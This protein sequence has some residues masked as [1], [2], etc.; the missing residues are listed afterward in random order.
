MAAGIKFTSSHFRLLCVGLG[1]VLL[2]AVG[3]IWNMERYVI[4][5]LGM[6]PT[7]VTGDVV[8]IDRSAYAQNTPQRGDIVFLE[9]PDE[10][11]M[12]KRIIGLPGETVEVRDSQVFVDGVLLEESYIDNPPPY[13]G[14]W[15]C[16]ADEYFVLGDN[17]ANSRDSHVFGPIPLEQISGRVLGY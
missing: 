14:S 7:I 9:I 15:T 13:E 5:G 6:A 3:C 17:R 4:E 11:P 8:T 2:L 16:G 12:I 1:A 10:R